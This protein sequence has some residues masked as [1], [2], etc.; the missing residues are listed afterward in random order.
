MCVFVC[1]CWC[2]REYLQFVIIPIQGLAFSGELPGNYT[3][4]SY[5][6][7]FPEPVELPT[8]SPTPLPPPPPPATDTLTLPL[9][10]TKNVIAAQFLKSHFIFHSCL[11]LAVMGSSL[12]KVPS[13]THIQRHTHWPSVTSDSGCNY[14]RPNALLNCTARLLLARR[15]AALS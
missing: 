12:H 14:D 1:V 3:L 4:L 13:V 7:I 9:Y 5:H 10:G 11:G 8:S 6:S 2:L 15:H